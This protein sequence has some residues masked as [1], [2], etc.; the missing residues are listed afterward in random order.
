MGK[1]T[2]KVWDN[3]EKKFT[4]QQCT[5]CPEDTTED[6]Y[7][8]L[9]GTYMSEVI[10]SGL[11]NFK[12]HCAMH[13]I[14]MN[15]EME[16]FKTIKRDVAVKQQNLLYMLGAPPQHVVDIVK[17]FNMRTK[18][19]YDRCINNMHSRINMNYIAML[20]SHKKEEW[21]E[22][23]QELKSM[24]P[25]QMRWLLED[26]F[27]EVYE[28]NLHVIENRKMMAIYNKKSK[29]MY[30]N[31]K[32]VIKNESMLWEYLVCTGGSVAQQNMSTLILACILQSKERYDAIKSYQQIPI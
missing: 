11:E 4:H 5:E 10:V 13:R 8:Q 22:K 29:K 15:Q 23:M 2:G 27:F 14:K 9:I 16:M 21:P 32:N 31:M 1:R 30:Q 7:H 6:L 26:D 12:N 28:M 18:E 24:V 25:K 3:E 19:E 17:A 20:R